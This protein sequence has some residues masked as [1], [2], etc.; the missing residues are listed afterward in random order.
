MSEFGEED[1]QT[2]RG[3]HAQTPE[4]DDVQ[5]IEPTESTGGEGGND[6]E[7]PNVP[8]PNPTNQGHHI[9]NL[10]YLVEQLQKQQKEQQTEA[11][12]LRQRL[13]EQEADRERREVSETPV[14]VKSRDVKFPNHITKFGDKQGGEVL[15][16]LT[17][18]DD[19]IEL[20]QDSLNTDE[21]K[22]I[23]VGGLLTGG[24]KDWYRQYRELPVS[25][26][27]EFM[28]D[29]HKFC[30]ELDRNWGDPDRKASYERK[31]LQLE[32]TSTVA[33][34][35]TEFR[36]YMAYLRYPTDDRL[37]PGTFY[38]GLKDEIKDEVMRE[39]REN[40]LPELIIQATRIDNRLRARRKE[41]QSSEKS[42]SRQQS[43]TVNNKPFVK[44]KQKTT[45]FYGG[46]QKKV[47]ASREVSTSTNNA[48]D[49]FKRKL[50]KDGKLSKEEKERRKKLNLCFFCGQA[51]HAWGDCELRKQRA[52]EKIGAPPVLFKGKQATITE[53]NEE[54]N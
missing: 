28:N 15:S 54:G 22:I 40:Q 52:R 16:F 32:Q 37:L 7:V 26:R 34:Y 18:C 21:K 9:K 30:Y 2:P 44:D 36:Q 25:D 43:A 35:A 39:G 11:A 24:P 4:S 17:D 33:K 23:L 46:G 12:N 8:V 29:Y 41:K 6:P 10:Q 48:K 49:D 20:N 3:S 45:T 38:K 13:A 1:M 42:D 47:Y 31:F 50:D 5:S 14:T 51:N 53:I 19:W 27:P